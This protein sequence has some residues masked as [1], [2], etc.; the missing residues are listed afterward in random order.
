MIII[1]VIRRKNNNSALMPSLFL[2][3]YRLRG[4]GKSVRK[5]DGIKALQGN[6]NALTGEGHRLLLLLFFF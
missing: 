3:F 4:Q 6:G 1:I 5:S 2:H